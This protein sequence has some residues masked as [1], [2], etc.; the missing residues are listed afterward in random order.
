MGASI[1]LSIIRLSFSRRETTGIDEVMKRGVHE[2]W[3]SWESCAPPR[4]ERT[5][6]IFDPKKRDQSIS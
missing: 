6:R 4:C 5:S 3:G 1:L 2:S